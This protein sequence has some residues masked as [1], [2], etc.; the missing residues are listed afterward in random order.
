[1]GYSINF[2]EKYYLKSG[3]DRNKNLIFNEYLSPLK[4]PKKNINFFMIY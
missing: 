4:Q 2:F 3:L 1:M